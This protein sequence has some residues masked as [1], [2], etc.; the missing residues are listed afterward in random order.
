[1]SRKPAY[2]IYDAL[3][4]KELLEILDRHPELRTILGKIDHEEQPARYATF[5]ARVIEQALREE[6]DSAA[7]LVL[8]N[9]LIEIISKRSEHLEQHQLVDA[10]RSIL[11]EITPPNYGT[12][13]VPR[14]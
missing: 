3:L 14:P 6:T 13:G 5:V 1:M 9:Q 12:S 4:D 10:Q 2:G 11:L 7:R 8:C